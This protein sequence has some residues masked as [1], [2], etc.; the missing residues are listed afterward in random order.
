MPKCD[1]QVLNGLPPKPSTKTKHWNQAM[2]ELKKYGENIEAMRDNLGGVKDKSLRMLMKNKAGKG[3]S[4]LAGSSSQNHQNSLGHRQK[5]DTSSG[6]RSLANHTPPV[7]EVTPSE[8][9]DGTGS[10]SDVDVSSPG[11]PPGLQIDLGGSGGGAH[12]S[13]S[14]KSPSKGRAMPS[15]GRGLIPSRNSQVPVSLDYSNNNG[16]QSVVVRSPGGAKIKKKGYKAGA[17]LQALVTTL[18]Q[19][20]RVAEQVG[21]TSMMPVAI[22]GA[23]DVGGAPGMGQEETEGASTKVTGEPPVKNDSQFSSI[24]VHENKTAFAIVD[25]NQKRPKRKTPKAAGNDGP[26]PKKPR[27]NNNTSGDLAPSPAN[28]AASKTGGD[29]DPLSL[30]DPAAL[31]AKVQ[32]FGNAA[33]HALSGSASGTTATPPHTVASLKA[34][35]ASVRSSMSASPQNTSGSS[36][37]SGTGP[38]TTLPGLPKSRT[39]GGKK[40]TKK[41]DK[42][43]GT[44]KSPFKGAKATT[45]AASMAPAAAATAIA[46]NVSSSAS[47]PQQV[48]VSPSLAALISA[49]AASMSTTSVAPAVTTSTTSDSSATARADFLSQVTQGA[50]SSRGGPSSAASGEVRGEVAAPGMASEEMSDFAEGTGLLADTIRKVNASFMARVNQITG[51]SD[52]MGYKYFVEKVFLM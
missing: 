30:S 52:D 33:I 38:A 22:R 26:P 7:V 2:F 51:P 18:A 25:P 46:T 21:S 4:Q 5:E 20:K 29:L 12:N 24:Y 37:H 31:V 10:L 44:G 19:R 23:G 8:G 3:S 1:I 49:P 42:G 15:G 43:R 47:I 28:A 32:E 50:S 40:K 34:N 41:S 45:S 9:A 11:T 35:A 27:T 39:T 13:S 14:E 6:N 48:G 17:A 16:A 36:N